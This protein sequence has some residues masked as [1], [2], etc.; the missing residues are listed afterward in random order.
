MEDSRYTRHASR[1]ADY[2]GRVI[3]LNREWPDLARPT[4]QNATRGRWHGRVA[5][6]TN[7]KRPCSEI[8]EKLLNQER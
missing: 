7:G 2:R 6:S 1:Q 4:C 8:G 3:S 5:L